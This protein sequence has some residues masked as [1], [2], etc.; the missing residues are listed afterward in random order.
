[1]HIGFGLV[2]FY[3]ISTIIGYQIPNPLY[4][5]IYI[6]MICKHILLIKSL[7][8]PKLILLLT[9]KFFPGFLSNTNNTIYN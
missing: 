3:D 4:T 7:N 8:E 5:Y 6:Y 1:M 9:V 2:G